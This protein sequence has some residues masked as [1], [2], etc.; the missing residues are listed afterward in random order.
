MT[1]ALHLFVVLACILLLVG[2]AAMIELQRQDR[3]ADRALAADVSALH[4]QVTSLRTALGALAVGSRSNGEADAR[5]YSD[6]Q[7]LEQA[8]A[9]QGRRTAYRYGVLVDAMGASR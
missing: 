7:A 2:G 9:A 5:L 8:V 3:E 6:V 1:R 4:Q